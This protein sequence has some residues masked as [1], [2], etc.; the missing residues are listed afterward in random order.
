MRQ[1]KGDA[2]FWCRSAPTFP[3][4]WS[5]RTATGPGVRGRKPQCRDVVLRAQQH[6]GLR[7]NLETS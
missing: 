5:L 4:A 7:D 1:G 3:V 2:V 6:V